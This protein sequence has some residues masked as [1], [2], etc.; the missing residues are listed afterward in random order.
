[1][2]FMGVDPG[3]DRCGYA[4]IDEDL[5]VITSGVIQ[6]NDTRTYWERV[7]V[8]YDAIGDVISSCRVK[9]AG[10]EKPFTGKNVGNGVEV[11]GAWAVI[12]LAIRRNQCQYMELH[13]T[14]V[15]AAVANGRA[16]KQQVKEGVEFILGIILNGLDDEADAFAAA[17]CTRDKWQL[18]EMIKAAQ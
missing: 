7:N 5:K 10:V 12:G 15:K 1:M 2:I 16:T 3:F 18:A 11:A 14:Q 13:N 6:T 8:V 4:V 17:I 9:V